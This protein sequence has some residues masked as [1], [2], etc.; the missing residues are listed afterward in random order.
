[1]LVYHDINLHDYELRNAK[2]HVTA[3]APTEAKGQFYLDEGDNFLKYYNGTEWVFLTGAGL[4]EGD[5]VSLLINDA[6]YLTSYTETDPV[7]L[8]HVSAGILA[9]D[10]V[11]WNLAFGWGNHALAGYITTFSE[12][13]T[14]HSVTTRN[15]VTTNNITVGDLVVSGNLTVS[16]TVTTINTE[17]ILLADNIITLNSNATGA[18][19]ENAGLLIER[20]DDTN[21]GFRWNESSNTWQ[22]QK[23]DSIYY[24]IEVVDPTGKI[25]AET[26]ADDALVSHNLNTLDIEVQMYDTVT[27]EIYHADWVRSNTNAITVSFYATPTN[28]IRVLINKIT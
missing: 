17:E 12:T 7:F 10:I 13:D 18:A 14:L 11:N 9:Q 1:M 22:I 20:G 19:T 6:G 26:I 5:N 28:S 8:A 27:L 4:L 23:N 2:V 3:V 21:R 15:P 24:D 16:G 25:Y